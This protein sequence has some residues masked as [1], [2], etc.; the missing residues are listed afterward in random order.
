[1]LTP[2]DKKLLIDFAGPLFAESKE[3]GRAHV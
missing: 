2:E 3:I 1:M